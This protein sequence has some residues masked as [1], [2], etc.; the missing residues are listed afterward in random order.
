M[1]ICQSKTLNSIGPY[2]QGIHLRL[3]QIGPD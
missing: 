3:D 2:N 1:G